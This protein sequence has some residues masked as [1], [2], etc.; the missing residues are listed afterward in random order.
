MNAVRSWLLIGGYRDT[1]NLAL[2]QAYEIQAIL[3]LAAPVEYP[4]VALLYL[5]VSDG[6]PLPFDAL[7]E[8]VAFVRLHKEQG[9]TVLVA[10]GA[11]VSR[12]AAFTTAVL[13]EEESLSLLDAY[14]EV[15]AKHSFALPHPAIWESLTEYYDEGPPFLEMMAQMGQS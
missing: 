5:P 13:K 2:I 8:G 10:C 12:S 11:G 9:H 15:K 7:R 14:R 6:F 1:K 3:Q 4:G